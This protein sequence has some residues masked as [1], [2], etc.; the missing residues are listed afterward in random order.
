MTAFWISCKNDGQGSFPFRCHIAETD[1]K[2][3]TVDSET[4]LRSINKWNF[5]TNTV[6][7]TLNPENISFVATRISSS[8]STVTKPVC[9]SELGITESAREIGFASLLLMTLDH[10]SFCILAGGKPAVY[11]RGGLFFLGSKNEAK[12]AFFNSWSLFF[13]PLSFNLEHKEEKIICLGRFLIDR[14]FLGIR[15]KM[16]ISNLLKFASRKNISFLNDQ[17]L[18][19]QPTSVLNLKFRAPKVPHIDFE[20]LILPETRLWVHSLIKRFIKVKKT[21]TEK[22]ELFYKKHLKGYHILG[23]HIRGTDHIIETDFK[24]LPKLDLWIK[25]TELIYTTMPS[26]K[27]I[28][29]AS[30]N[31][32]SLKKFVDYF[33]EN[34]VSM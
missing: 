15:S 19:F 11:W 30:D 20:G 23:V 5:T 26:P 3:S 13:E 28:F 14:D 12:K 4:A 7:Q 21:I 9:F 22:S 27:K 10:I 34:A 1:C 25:E 6:F 8:P 32:E 18:S 17:N 31:K 33:G 29:V 24:K 2:K 16:N